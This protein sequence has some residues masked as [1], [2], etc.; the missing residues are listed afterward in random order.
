MQSSM[1]SKAMHG[2]GERVRGS[3]LDGTQIGSEAARHR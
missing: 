1:G 2:M 3:K